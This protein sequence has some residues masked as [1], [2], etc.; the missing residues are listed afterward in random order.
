MTDGSSTVFLRTMVFLGALWG[1]A[2]LSAGSAGVLALGADLMEASE[3][4]GRL[5]MASD[6]QD[7]APGQA[8][9]PGPSVRAGGLPGVLLVDAETKPVVTVSW[10]TADGQR[11]LSSRV[12]Y[13]NPDERTLLGENIEAF[14]AMGGTR[15]DTGQ[16]HPAGAVLRVGL[17]KSRDEALFFE[18]ATPDTVIELSLAGVRFAGPAVALPETLLQH[19][20]Y[21]MADIEACGLGEEN[22]DLYLTRSPTDTLT[23]RLEAGRNA[24]LGVL[25]DGSQPAGAG[26]WPAAS[27]SV[28]QS[29]D[30]SFTLSVRFPY[31]WL[32][33]PLDP[34]KSDAPGT[35]FEPNHFHLEVEALP[36]GVDPSTRPAGRKPRPTT[37][38]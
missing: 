9:L 26:D 38:D 12:P 2:A 13:T 18:G 36:E 29:V 35:F 6:N 19:V 25:S 16:G 27:A 31:R 10:T 11:R 22:A 7:R 32:R 8:G 4:I 14:A 20:K 5:A 30:G 1:S 37:L 34:W 24:R 15:L 33:H 23:G 21:R 28:D 17:Y 3:P